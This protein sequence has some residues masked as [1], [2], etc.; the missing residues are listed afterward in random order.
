MI[1]S[2][3]LPSY[4]VSQRIHHPMSSAS[5]PTWTCKFTTPTHSADKQLVQC[6]CWGSGEQVIWDRMAGNWTKLKKSHQQRRTSIELS[7]LHMK[8]SDL[9]WFLPAG[10]QGVQTALS[11]SW[12]FSIMLTVSTLNTFRFPGFT[13]P[14]HFF[15]CCIYFR[16]RQA[17]HGI[18]NLCQNPSEGKTHFCSSYGHSCDRH[19]FELK[20]YTS[21]NACLTTH[22]TSL[23]LKCTCKGVCCPKDCTKSQVP[24]QKQFHLGNELVSYRSRQMDFRCLIT[25]T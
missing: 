1:P 23:Q 22:A 17:N 4:T 11:A 14:C 10:D 2:L 15:K 16:L 13:M 12:P 20:S 5:P 9:T 24:S 18:F 19:S 3:E 8:V 6:L 25:S 21:R 7:F